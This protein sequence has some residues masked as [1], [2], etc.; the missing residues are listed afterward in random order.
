MTQ[1][2]AAEL[3]RRYTAESDELQRRY[4]GDG[5]ALTAYKTFTALQLGY[6]LPKYDDLRDHPGYDAAIDFVISDLV[7]PSIADRDREL[8]RVVPVMS[9]LLP[10]KALHALA[11]TMELN[12]RVLRINLEIEGG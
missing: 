11:L 4:L 5:A 3:F 1:D 12:A 8:E 10:S 2:K 6:F 7:G 9:R